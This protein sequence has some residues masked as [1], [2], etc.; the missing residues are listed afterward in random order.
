MCK[1][2]PITKEHIEQMKSSFL[3]RLENPSLTEEQ[4]RALQAQYDYL[5]ENAKETQG[6]N[7]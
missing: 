4:R 7:V 3:R 5:V 2:N 6:V 1:T